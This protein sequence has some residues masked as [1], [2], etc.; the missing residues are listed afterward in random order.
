M[1][2]TGD[3]VQYE[4]ECALNKFTKGECNIL[5][6]TSV[7]ARGLDIPEVGLVINF[8]LPRDPKEYIHRIG[9]SGRC[10]KNGRSIS[11]LKVKMM[12]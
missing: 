4:R 11:F 10:G 12:I 6:A 9:R 2:L 3:K 8:D 1:F 5:V 7:A